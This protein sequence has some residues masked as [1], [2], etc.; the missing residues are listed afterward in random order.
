MRIEAALSV[1]GFNYKTKLVL[2]LLWAYELAQP[3][4]S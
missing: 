1:G 3:Y 4:E 2:S